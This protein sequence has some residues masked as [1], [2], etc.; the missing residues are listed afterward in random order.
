M[1]VS[2]VCILK[3]ATNTSIISSRA[4]A[5]G[6]FYRERKSNLVGCFKNY[7]LARRSCPKKTAQATIALLAACRAGLATGTA[8]LIAITRHASS[9]GAT[10]T[11]AGE[12]ISELHTLPPV[13][14]ILIAV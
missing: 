8:T 1:Y 13:Q 2:H 12:G 6:L 7:S 14:R 10:A 3:I 11:T 9:T 5:E 4:A